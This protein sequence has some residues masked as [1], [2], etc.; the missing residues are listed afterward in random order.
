MSWSWQS[1]SRRS[2]RC[3]PPPRVPGLPPNPVAVPALAAALAPFTAFW[4][5]PV[6]VLVAAASLVIRYRSGHLAV[7]QQIKWFA[8][9]AVVLAVCEA[10]NT[11]LGEAALAGVLDAVGKLAVVAAV[12]VAVLRH[13]LYDVDLAI[14]RTL[15]Y[16]WLAVL[17]TAI[18]VALVVGVGSA[19]GHPAGSGSAAVAGRHDRGRAGV[20]PAAVAAAGAGQPAGLRPTAGPVRVAGRVHPAAGRP[21]RH[22]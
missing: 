18:Y 8:L 13:R 17:V 22:R 20:P 9:S 4:T 10:G 3:S 1:W 2:S 7:R 5:F 6:A 12:G 16:G 14:S 21:L 19:V 11:A 15:A